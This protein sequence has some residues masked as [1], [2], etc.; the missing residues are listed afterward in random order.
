M[1][2]VETVELPET[3]EEL[4]KYT[5]EQ[6]DDF[7]QQLQA[8]TDK[9]NNLNIKYSEKVQAYDEKAQ[10]YLEISEKYR[11]LHNS[12]F[13]RSSEKWSVDEKLQASLFNEAELAFDEE[14]IEQADAD[15]ITYTVTKKRRGKRQPIPENI[16]R[17][18][19]ILDIPDEE[20]VCEC[21][22]SLVRI[23]EEV[24]EKL[25]IIPA[26]VKVIRY[27]RP[28]WACSYCEG[29][30]D[31]NH[32]AV[33]IAPPAKDLLPKSLASAGLVS[34]IITSKYC[35]TL[36]LYR[37]EKIYKRIGVEIKR[38]SMARWIISLAER[39][40]PLLELM[41]EAIRGGPLIQM[42]ETSLQVHGEKGRADHTKSYMWVALGGS[43]ENQI[44]RYLYHPSR[45]SEI[46]SAYLK[47]Y[48]GYLQTDAYAGYNRVVEDED[49]IH[50]LC[51]AHAR[52]KFDEASKVKGGSPSARE[53]VSIIQRIYRV[54][55]ELRSK[56]LDDEVFISQRKEQTAPF[57]EKLEKQLEKKIT[58]VV[59][60]SA[61]GRAIAYT[62][63]VL[64]KVKKYLEL[65]CLTP[66]NNAAERSIRPF[67][68][69]RKNRMHCDSPSGAHASACFYSL[70]ESA[71]SFGLE[72]YWYIR[73][74]LKKLPEVEIQSN[75]HSL[76]PDAI[77]PEILIASV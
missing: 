69:G 22:S 31:E 7:A 74:I 9:Y 75:W 19:I 55:K 25:D 67:V 23:G 47:G 51:L 73:H 46:P 12:F 64:P 3:I 6:R 20:K 32:P 77:T 29:S 45:R 17:E 39:L 68:L 70:I 35:D 1:S 5:L 72:P 28:K 71:K 65:A 14:G 4:K 27:V 37:Q 33:R 52:R 54:E 13:G 30:G 43:G 53:F 61:L 44:I 62:I 24:S 38:S 49:I 57:F 56:K 10:D 50:V 48:S 18:E 41:D 60:S 8:L 66:D 40:S 26:Q 34:H 2:V 11:I 16:P 76:L 36:P 21:G 42:D 15:T 59:P 58:Q 63:D